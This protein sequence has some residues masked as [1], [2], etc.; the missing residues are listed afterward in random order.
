MNYQETW[1]TREK[2]FLRK[3][4]PR[5]V[6]VRRKGFL[7]PGIIFFIGDREGNVKKPAAQRPRVGGG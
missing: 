4:T 3:S 7:L 5:M 6:F 1:K 2:G